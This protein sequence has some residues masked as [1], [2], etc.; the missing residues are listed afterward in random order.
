MRR[1]AAF[2]AAGIG[3]VCLVLVALAVWLHY[4]PS[5]GHL[6]VSATSLVPFA[7][8]PAVVAVLLFGATRRWGL[9]GVG[10]AL[11]VALCVTQAPLW[12]THTPPAG[13]RFRVVSANLHE[14]RADVDAIARL[15][16]DAELVAL[17]EVTP[18]ALD[19]LRSGPLGRRM[20]YEYAITDSSVRG[21]ALFSRRPLTSTREV[22]GMSNHDLTVR[23]DLPG[24]T[25]VQVLAVHPTAPTDGR[26]GQWDADMAALAEQ[27]RALPGGPVLVLGDLNATWDHHRYRD[28][29]VAGVADTS[30]QAGAGFVP[31]WPTN[32]FTRRPVVG[33]D[34]ALTRGFV[35]TSVRG[36][37]LPGTDHRALV[38]QLVPAPH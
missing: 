17:L 20:P 8:V 3:V 18:H 32:R 1:V 24:T 4:Y 5:R 23:T 14:G 21:A 2:A 7:I 26:T 6:S 29:L 28:L 15:G 33:I 16:A 22:G 19:A 13:E 35:A 9:L 36:V 31:T 34:H 27:L 11:T 25:G 37:D 38:T 12:I 30:G 10:L